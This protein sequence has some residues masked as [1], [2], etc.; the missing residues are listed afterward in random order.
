MSM[1]SEPSFNFTEFSR[2]VLDKTSGK[3][4]S[5]LA[6]ELGISRKYAS[7]L[8]T[9]EYVGSNLRLLVASKLQISLDKCIFN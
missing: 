9:G 6:E 5:I 4:N 8:R 2:Q 3:S 7:K 1:K